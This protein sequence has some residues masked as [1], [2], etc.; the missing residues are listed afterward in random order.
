MVTPH[1]PDVR[2]TSR[3]TVTETCA[4]LSIHRCTLL[5]YTKRGL[6]KHGIDRVTHRKTYP[7]SEIMKLWRRMRS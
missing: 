2:P 4:L 3:Y 6:I 5:N 1:E 7:G